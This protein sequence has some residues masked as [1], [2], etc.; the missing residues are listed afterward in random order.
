ME[1]LNV[2]VKFDGEF[3]SIEN[4]LNE[5]SEYIDQKED[6]DTLYIYVASSKNFNSKE[7]IDGQT[8]VFTDKEV[9][10]PH[11]ICSDLE[12]QTIDALESLHYLS[13]GGII[14]ITLGEVIT[15]LLYANEFIFINK[16]NIKILDA[17]SDCLNSIEI[18]MENVKKIYTNIMISA[19]A[20]YNDF[21]D[22]LHL[23]N[24]NINRNC[25]VIMGQIFNRKITKH[26]IFAVLI[27]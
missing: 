27:C 4:Y 1:K 21:S 6:E 20:E 2:V 9:E 18:D 22:S 16:S 15:S 19:E 11:M 12:Q 26:V 5:I 3:P 14:N 7:I 25:D 24:Q 8:I 17:M 23:L 10:Y 13:F